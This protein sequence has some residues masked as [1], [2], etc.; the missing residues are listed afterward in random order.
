MAT[1]NTSKEHTLQKTRFDPSSELLITDPDIIPLINHEKKKLI[2]ELLL[3]N[4]KTIMEISKATGWNPGTVKR[5]LT[6]LVNGGLVV[7]ARE[8]FNQKKILL[9]YYRTASKHFTFH[10]EWPTQA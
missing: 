6:D 8:E 4:E 9:K 2:L 1:H 10:F 7:I 5:H 3:V